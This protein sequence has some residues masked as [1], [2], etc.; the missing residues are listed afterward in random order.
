MYANLKK[1]ST[2]KYSTIVL[3]LYQLNKLHY[4]YTIAEGSISDLQDFI[5]RHIYSC[6]ITTFF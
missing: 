5:N 2:F 6:M 3:F 4:H 1:N